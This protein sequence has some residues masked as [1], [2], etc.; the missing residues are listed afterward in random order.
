MELTLRL[1]ANRYMVCYFFMQEGYIHAV[2][3]WGN[4]LDFVWNGVE[5]PY[6]GADYHEVKRP[7]RKKCARMVFRGVCLLRLQCHRE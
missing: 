5:V 3:N 2:C 7:F 1:S 4:I 6:P